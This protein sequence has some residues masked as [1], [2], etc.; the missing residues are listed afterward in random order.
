[1]IKEQLKLVPSKPGSYQMKDTYGN[2]IY[3]GKAKNLKNR[4]TTY[5]TG[6][7]DY[8]TTKMI[9]AIESFDYI[10]TNTELE[11]LILEIDLIKKYQP[12]YN[13][14]LTDDKSYPYI[15][16]TNERHPKLVVTRPMNKTNK[17]LFGPYPNVKAARD[18]LKLLNKL[19]PLRK[20]HKLPKEPCLYYHLG[21]CLA[22]CINKVEK[23]T[24]KSIEKEISNFLKG[25]IQKTIKSLEKQMYEASE[26]LEFERAMEYKNTIEAIQTTTSKQVVNLSDLKDRDIIAVATD[27]EHVA[28][29]TFFIRNGKISARDKKLMPYYLEKDQSVLDYL[30]Q[31]YQ[32]YPIPKEILTNENSLLKTLEDLFDTQVITPVRGPK[33]QLLDL[34]LVNA[35]QS[36]SE[37]TQI[38]KRQMEKTFGALDE[39]AELLNIPTP[40]HIEAFDNSH[41]FGSYPV[42]SMVVFKNAQPSKNDYR[43]YKLETSNIQS[44]DTQQMKEVLYRRYQRVLYDSLKQP[45]LII[46]D[47][48]I[49]QLNTA[50]QVI[51]ELNL[52]IPIAGLV[53]SSN[54][55]THHLIDASDT[56]IELSPQSK[57]FH[58]LSFIQ[59]EAH[60]FAINFHKNLRS[61]GI[62]STILDNIDGVGETTKKKLLKHFK[63]IQNMKQATFEDFKAL[64]IPKKTIEAIQLAL[65]KED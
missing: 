30:I 42:S 48:G 49:H 21:Q 20:C 27:D 53:K 58:L 7:H 28:L 2:I 57:L 33:K 5:F 38:I 61:K 51:K 43:K 34:A 29:D 40:Y 23:E 10:V 3:V 31:F 32:A 6:S 26:N 41:L 60:R 39:L 25:D 11:A 37:Q 62:Y 4:L 44:G 50:K 63:T 52:N 35:K 55:K 45:D 19:Y 24:Y 1:M 13:I 12:R 59:E 22:P 15:E 64:G 8:K 47:G 54:H 17:N 14:L 65:K 56:E 9:Q 36:L 18:T 46:V 16:I